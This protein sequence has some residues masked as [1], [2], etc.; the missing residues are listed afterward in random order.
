MPKKKEIIFYTPM[1]EK[2]KQYNDHLVAKTL[3]EYFD[4]N[5]NTPGMFC[6]LSLHCSFY[7]LASDHDTFQIVADGLCSEEVTLCFLV[8]DFRIV[9]DFSYPP[10]K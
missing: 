2:Q 3:A 5:G 6:S 7:Q 10:L 4:E 8:L 9:H 1:T